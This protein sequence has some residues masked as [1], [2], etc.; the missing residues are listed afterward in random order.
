MIGS[1]PPIARLSAKRPPSLVDQVTEGLSLQIREGVFLAGAMLPSVQT[2]STT[3]GV[4]RT[5][6]RE[7]LSRMSAQGL[8]T[9]RQ[10]LGVFVAETLP[11]QQ[12]EFTTSANGIE[13]IQILELRLGLETEAAGF[14]ALRRN[15]E[16]IAAMQATLAAME[17]CIEAKDIEKSIEADLDFHRSICVATRNPHFDQL[18]L[19]LSQFVR[20]NIS[21]SRR[22]SATAEG[23]G[24]DAQEEHSAIFVAIRE[25]APEAARQ[26][27]RQHV[28]NTARRLD[29]RLDLKA[30]TAVPAASAASTNL[31]F[32]KTNAG[33]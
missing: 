32:A 1:K 29:L 11:S 8:V 3:W 28:V 26:A 23:R 14:A 4:S 2:L 5:V 9:S 19:F 13:L 12:L 27:A 16:D 20:D 30:A 33:S 6:M 15:Q 7:A 31:P 25:G 21:I 17:H 18:F 10:G 24:M 22:N